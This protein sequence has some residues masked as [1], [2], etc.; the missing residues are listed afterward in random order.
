VS[1]RLIES[2]RPDDPLVVVRSDFWAF[3]TIGLASG[4][5]A[6]V[7]DPGIKPEDIQL[8]TDSLPAEV[9]EVLIT[10]SHHDHIRGWHR[11]P[12]AKVS[13]PRVVADKRLDAQARILRAKAKIDDK[14]GI[15]DPEFSY[16]TAD[17][18][19]DD[20][21]E[22]MIG[23][24]PAEMIFLPGHSNCTSVVYFPNIAT[25]C[26]ADYLVSP[27]LPYCRWQAREFESA[28]RFLKSFCSERAVDRIV[29]AH[30]DLIHG[31]AAI[32]QALLQ[33]STYFESLRALVTD[34]LASG[35]SQESTAKR[36]ATE[37]T[38][39]RGVDLRGREPQDLDNA[40]RVLAEL[41]D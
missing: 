32:E 16:P 10:H 3:N 34:I 12:G 36:A 29:P 28:I 7:I 27:G 21:L 40:R 14:L 20:R 15:D 38:K 22:L 25:L 2:D 35:E 5:Q 18:V 4:G 9:N 37:M 24:Q 33:E 6:C 1:S 39:R 41:A 19:F 30:N 23:E 13:M 8:L 11:F 31:S 17:R 26:T